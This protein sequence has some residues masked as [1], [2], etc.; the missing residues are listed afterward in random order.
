ME[1]SKQRN[2]TG[3]FG[4]RAIILIIFLVLIFCIENFSPIIIRSSMFYTYLVKPAIWI[5]IIAAVLKFPKVH[6]SGKLRLKS[7][8]QCL[9]MILS[10]SFILIMMLAGI[11]SG[12]GKS[13]YSHTLIGVVTNII[14]VFSPLIARELIRDYLVNNPSIKGNLALIIVITLFMT[15]CNLSIDMLTGLKTNLDIVKYTTEIILPELGNNIL[16][17]YL[18]FLG[19]PMLSIIYLGIQ[20]IF[21]WFFPILPNLDWLVKGL[22]CTLAPI[23]SLLLIQFIYKKRMKLIEDNETKSENPI[24]WILTSL[25]SISIIWFAVGVFPIRPMVIATGS[26]EPVIYAGDMVLVKRISP[27]ELKI[28]DIIQYKSG[29]IFIFHRIIEAVADKDKLKYR[30]KGDN[31]SI[32]DHELVSQDNIK[33]KVVYTVPKIGWPI[34]LLKGDRSFDKTKVQ[35]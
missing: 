21:Y 5:A 32:Y 31:N 30:T 2:I 28:G 29:N 11:I 17:S 3:G 12:F 6:P 19:G 14:I 16:S 1:I 18:V 23:F 10:G 9:C 24:G 4:K 27:K 35:F 15:I 13:P 33:G 7:M 22:V 20:Q 8:L 25:L 26:M 34:L